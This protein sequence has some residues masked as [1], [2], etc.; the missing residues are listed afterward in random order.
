MKL[1]DTPS[2]KQNAMALTS[3]LVHWPLTDRDKRLFEWLPVSAK[4]SWLSFVRDA[5]PQLESWLQ[6]Q[7]PQRFCAVAESIHLPAKTIPNPLQQDSVL[8]VEIPTADDTVADWQASA[9]DWV[10]L[11][12]DSIDR[13]SLLIALQGAKLFWSP[14]RIAIFAPSER[15]AVIRRAVVEFTFYDAQLR[16][17]ERDIRD[18]WSPLAEDAPAAFEFPD[19]MH[20]KRQQ[21]SQRFQEY[22]GLRMRVARLAPH[23]DIPLVHPPTIASQIGERLRERTRMADRHAFLSEQLEVFEHVYEMCG[24]RVSD[25]VLA[26]TGHYLEWIIILLLLVQT[27]LSVVEAASSAGN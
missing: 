23:V 18:G 9:S 6:F 12:A 5:N 1:I 20:A 25:A 8:I 14:E 10:G 26:R 4:L 19:K 24:Q 22:V 27:I 15:L 11:T 2:D 16:S 7:D 3:D 21:L 17:I 13:R